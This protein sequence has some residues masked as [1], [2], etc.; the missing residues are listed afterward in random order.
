MS[1]TE[2]HTRLMELHFNQTQT[3]PIME[4]LRLRTRKQ[5]QVQLKVTYF[6]EIAGWYILPLF[7]YHNFLLLISFC[8]ESIRTSN[9]T[10]TARIGLE[11]ICTKHF[12][13]VAFTKKMIITKKQ[14]KQLSPKY[15]S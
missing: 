6:K 3:M 1:Y 8:Y 9:I 12:L 11:R 10:A 7:L 14:T 2:M 15:Q 4:H 5:Q 13:N